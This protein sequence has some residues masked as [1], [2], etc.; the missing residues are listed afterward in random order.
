M[1]TRAFVFVLAVL[2]FIPQLPASQVGAPPNRGRSSQTVIANYPIDRVGIFILTKNF[3]WRPIRAGMM[4]EVRVRRGFP[5]R[6]PYGN[7]P[8]VGIEGAVI[9]GGSR[10]Q[11]TASR[12]VICICQVPFNPGSPMLVR[13]HAS[14]QGLVIEGSKQLFGAKRAKEE[15]SGLLR[16]SISRPEPEV[17]LIQPSQALSRGNYG[18]I[19]PNHPNLIYH[20]SVT[21]QTRRPDAGN[22]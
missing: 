13:L 16:L 1:R 10:I 4:L 11:A 20:F 14:G 3:D 15:E 7:P 8:L 22:N 21:S 2:F 6:W 5:D 12:P 17:W 19:F 18:V 9:G